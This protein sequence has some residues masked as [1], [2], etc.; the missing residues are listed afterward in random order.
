MSGNI[1]EDLWHQLTQDVM[2][3]MREWRRQHPKAILRAIATELDA[4]LNRMRARM[5]TD[6]AL[7]STTCTRCSRWSGRD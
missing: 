7:A 5:L 3:G 1:N 4:Q 6:I 2:T